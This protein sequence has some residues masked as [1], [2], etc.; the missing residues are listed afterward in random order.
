M[1]IGGFN[2]LTTLDFPGVVS[3]IVFTQGCNFACPYCH[4]PGLI[5]A[6]GEALEDTGEI[7]AYLK[8]RQGILGGV[9]VTGGE[10]TIHSELQIFCQ[11]LK[12][13]KYKVKFDTNGSNP[14]VLKELIALELL[15]YI[16]MDL[17]APLHAYSAF[18][19][20]NALPQQLSESI[21]IIRNSGLAHEFRTTCAKPFTTPES[22]KELA[23][24][25]GSSPWFLQTVR[26]K[27]VFR[28][29]YEMAEIH[30]EELE[31]LLPKLRLL[32]PN[33]TLRA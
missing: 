10:P 19:A 1:I 32:A 31:D 6:R 17:K 4:N 23:R 8:K 30:R 29:E 25:P 2:K 7:L 3:A 16:A 20:A 15:D 22:L 11:E 12:N 24:L 13:L 28:P 21:D 9:V 18:S 14:L 27:D 5:P 26:L 33:V